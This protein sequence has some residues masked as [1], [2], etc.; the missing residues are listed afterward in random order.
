MRSNK[1]IP[2]NGKCKFGLETVELENGKCID[3]LNFTKYVDGKDIW[4]PKCIDCPF[5]GRNPKDTSEILEAYKGEEVYKESE[6]DSEKNIP[7]KS[8]LNEMWK[9]LKRRE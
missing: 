5:F 2:S 9:T 3:A 7:R 6:G 8:M 1:I 4:N